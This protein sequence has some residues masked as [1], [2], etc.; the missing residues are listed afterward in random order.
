MGGYESVITMPHDPPYPPLPKGGNTGTLR[1]RLADC[2]ATCDRTCVP[3]LR[4]AGYNP[5]MNDDVQH[6]KLLTVFHYVLAGITA[7]MG[8]FPVFHLAVGIA[9]LSGHL[10][11]HPNNPAEATLLGWI[12]TGAAVVMITLAWSFA[13][14]LLCA[15]RFLQQQRR[16]T[17]CLVVAGA[18]CLMMPFGTVL[19]VFTIIV[20]LRPSVRQLF[21]ED[22][23][24]TESGS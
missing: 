11:T 9:V 20:L 23:G 22:D 2:L 7:L 16:R 3:T 4:P 19:G 5:A 6:L 17:F 24:A 18:E 8:C 15:G 12:F 21:D 14:A 13:I 10:E 1:D